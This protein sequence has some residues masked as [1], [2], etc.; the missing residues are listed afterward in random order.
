MCA[1]L[2][3]IP[4]AA[5]DPITRRKKIVTDSVLMLVAN[6]TSS[7]LGFVRGFYIARLLA[8]AEFGFWSLAA[9]AFNYAHYA[10]VGLLNGLLVETGRLTGR[11]QVLEAKDVLRQGYTGTLLLSGSVAIVGSPFPFFRR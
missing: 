6:A 2:K 4:E 5:M 8:P 10:D 9:T 3:G 11:K 1:G 7:A